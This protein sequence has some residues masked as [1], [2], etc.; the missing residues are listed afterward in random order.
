MEEQELISR[1]KDGDV[2]S[3]NELVE[4]Y[5]KQVYNLALQMLRSPQNAE[6]A[7][8]DA[9]LSAWRAISRFRGGNFKTWLLRIVANTC[10]DQFRL[11]KRRPSSSLDSIVETGDL[12]LTID[13]LESPEGYASQ[14]ELGWIINE[15]L[16]F[17]SEEQRLVV[18]LS[19]IQ[20][21]SYEEIA[22]IT[23]A[24]LGTVK[25]RLS[26]GRANLRKILSQHN[27]WR[28]F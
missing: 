5:Q 18:I 22:Q 13:P 17:L 25:S 21:L 9:F 20:E 16:S 1:S 24:P 11:A 14:Q 28:M 26:R 6:D 8:Q 4:K 10:R 27:N 12:P 23:K 3:F 2:D 15:A 7:T 19:D